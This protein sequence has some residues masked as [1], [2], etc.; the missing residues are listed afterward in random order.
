MTK[1]PKWFQYLLLSKYE[2]IFTIPR[3]KKIQDKK[4]IARAKVEAAK[5]LLRQENAQEP[6]SLI[7]DEED[8]DIM[9]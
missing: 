1:T 4:K 3:L 8:E 9:F 6:T 5:A 2:K 7:E